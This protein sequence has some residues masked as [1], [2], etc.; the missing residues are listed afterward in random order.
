VDVALAPVTVKV[1]DE[2]EL[3]VAGTEVRAQP[4][5]TTGCTTADLVLT[6]GTT[7]ANGEVRSSLPSGSYT[8]SVVGRTSDGGW[9]TTP[10]YL[11]PDVEHVQPVAVI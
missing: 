8:I 5:V 7:D 4:L 1:A 6:L 3:P 10:A 9:P 2:N 11:P